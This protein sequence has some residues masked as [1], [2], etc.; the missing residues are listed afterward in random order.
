MLLFLTIDGK[1]QNIS[2]Q[3]IHVR[4]GDQPGSLFSEVR[5]TSLWYKFYFPYVHFVI[6]QYYSKYRNAISAA[7]TAYR[8]YFFLLAQAIRV[9][10]SSNEDEPDEHLSTSVR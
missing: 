8:G 5:Q 2:T 7:S 4:K 10:K 1:R 3:R 9:R 6:P